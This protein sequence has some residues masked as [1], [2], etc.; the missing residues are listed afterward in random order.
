M[1]DA[2]TSEK[3]AFID[4]FDNIG[5]T[6]YLVKPIIKISKYH[7]LKIIFEPKINFSLLGG[8]SVKSDVGQ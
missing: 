1:F 7:I 6:A 2:K 5:Q 8:N 4:V 3:Y